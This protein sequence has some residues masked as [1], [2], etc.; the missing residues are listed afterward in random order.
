MLKLKYLF[1]LTHHLFLWIQTNEMVTGDNFLKINKYLKTKL[2]YWYDI[3]VCTVELPAWRPRGPLSLV[4]SVRMCATNPPV[5]TLSKGQLWNWDLISFV[6]WKWFLRIGIGPRELNN[7]KDTEWSD[8]V[9][10]CRCIKQSWTN[11][12]TSFTTKLQRSPCCHP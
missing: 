12:V 5:L 2:T 1:W 3:T 6:L 9:V 8:Q 10:H 11:T 4:I 7:H